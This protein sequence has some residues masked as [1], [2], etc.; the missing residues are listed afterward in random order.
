MSLKANQDIHEDQ[1]IK[2]K[3]VNK[4]LLKIKYIINIKIKIL[5]KYH[6]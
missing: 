3:M 2:W 5:L 6:I 4:K 1:T